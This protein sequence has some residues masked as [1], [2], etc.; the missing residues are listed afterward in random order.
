M[1]M[2]DI[3]LFAKNEKELK[4]LMHTENIQ[5]GHGIWYCKMRNASKE[6]LQTT[7]DGRNGTTK[8]RKN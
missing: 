5:S 1:Y 4:T 8:L 3:K 7:S 6:N 2:D